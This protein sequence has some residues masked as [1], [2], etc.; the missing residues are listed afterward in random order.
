VEEGNDCISV[1]QL[2]FISEFSG[3]AKFGLA[4]FPHLIYMTI[5]FTNKIDHFTRIDVDRQIRFESIFTLIGTNFQTS[6]LTFLA[7]RS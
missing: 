5:Y 3:K 2:I 6:N 4:L 1:Q 7:A